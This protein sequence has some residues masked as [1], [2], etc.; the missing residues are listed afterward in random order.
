MH[1]R[2]GPPGKLKT[3]A[4]QPR[5]LPNHLVR[6]LVTFKVYERVH[7]SMT[8]STWLSFRDREC[9]VSSSLKRAITLSELLLPLDYT[10]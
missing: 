4:T 6:H 5:P 1:R 10:A 9:D 7:F 3:V 8:P 2:F